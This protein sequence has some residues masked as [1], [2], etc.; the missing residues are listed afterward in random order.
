MIRDKV[1]LDRDGLI[2]WLVTAGRPPYPFN[3]V[4]W[5]VSRV[6]LVFTENVM[7]DSQGNE[8]SVIWGGARLQV[9]N[10]GKM[11]PADLPLDVYTCALVFYTPSKPSGYVWDDTI[12]IDVR[13][14]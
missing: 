10:P 11:L 2:D 3:L 8:Q 9:K 6:Q 1:Y 4:T 14:A 13:K 7:I 12:E 5:G